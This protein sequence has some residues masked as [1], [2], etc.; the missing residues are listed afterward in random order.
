MDARHVPGPILPTTLCGSNATRCS[1]AMPM[2]TEWVLQHF[3]LSSAQVARLGEKRGAGM[4][5]LAPEPS[6]C[7]PLLPELILK[8]LEHL[9]PNE[10]ALGGRLTCKVA[11]WRFRGPPFCTVRLS[12]ALPPYATD[13]QLQQNCEAALRSLTIEGKLRTL[14]TAVASGCIT[15]LEL[16]WTVVRPCLFEEL[17]TSERP[18]SHVHYTVLLDQDDDPGAVAYRTGNDHL[19]PW[20]LHHCV[21]FD[22]QVALA[23]AAQHCDLP[24]LQA[25][26]DLLSPRLNSNF[27]TVHLHKIWKAAAGSRDADHARGK[28]AWLARQHAGPTPLDRVHHGAALGA[29]EAGHFELLQWM[30]SEGYTLAAAVD[31]GVRLVGCA[32][33]RGE[34]HVARWLR[35]AVN[36]QGQ[37]YELS[38]LWDHAAFCGNVE[39]LQWLSELGVPGASHAVR[40]AAEAGRL[41]AVQHLHGEVV[42]Q[43][44]WLDPEAFGFAAGSGSIPTAVWLRQQGYLMQGTAYVQA[45]KRGDA[46]VL[47]WMVQEARCPWEEATLSKVIEVWPKRLCSNWGSSSS[48]SSSSSARL[49]QVVKE[50]LDAGCP[51]GPGGLPEAVRRGDLPLARYLNE[52]R[53]SGFSPRV[54]G[55]A[56]ECGCEVVLEWLWEAGCPADESV[57]NEE[58][59]AWIIGV[60][61]EFYPYVLAGRNGDLA[62]LSLMRRL[63]VPWGTRVVGAACEWGSSLPVLRWMAEQGAPLEHPGDRAALLTAVQSNQELGQFTES[64]A[65]L[66]ENVPGL[67]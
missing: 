61:L 9:S 20:L 55:A 38:S 29:A 4:D 7:S 33:R 24:G 43:D 13:P 44:E 12:E 40:S 50:L 35:E 60:G 19:V 27:R 64:V 49:L 53:G 1:L 26:W 48:S 59:A 25:A 63:G 6:A 45:A 58:D 65:W 31:E 16:A 37:G 14:S 30:H 5:E 51:V 11:A 47:R 56:A 18:A 67:Y 39:Q 21:P 34:L 2:I 57:L 41:E 3:G 10:C 52:E 42:A 22:P 17:L 36:L 15:N 54:L 32:L 23:A 66:E 28:L 62:T 8:V 46:E